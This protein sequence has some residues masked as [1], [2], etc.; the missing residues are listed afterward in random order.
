MTLS[1][2]SDSRIF[3]IPRRKKQQKLEDITL[4]LISCPCNLEHH[5]SLCPIFRDCGPSASSSHLSYRLR[6]E[7]PNYCWGV[8]AGV[9][10]SW[11]VGS[12]G[13]GEWGRLSTGLPA[14]W[15]QQPHFSLWRA[16]YVTLHLWERGVLLGGD[17]DMGIIYCHSNSYSCSTVCLSHLIHSRVWLVPYHVYPPACMALLFVILIHIYLWLTVYQARACS[18]V[19]HD[20]TACT[21]PLLH[22]LVLAGIRLYTHSFACS[23]V[24]RV[25]SEERSLCLIL[26]LIV[27][28]QRYLALPGFISPFGS[29]IRSTGSNFPL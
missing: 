1:F 19:Y 20:S 5:T 8:G 22:V 13:E 9:D 15:W 14:A 11:A 17:Q 18:V 6:L 21:H 7:I 28:F 16:A 12:R 3:V 29:L 10:G 24:F 27:Y 23:F 4:S 26:I 2:L 25:R